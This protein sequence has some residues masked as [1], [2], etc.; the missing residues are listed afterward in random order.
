M[1]PIR[2]SRT[3][4]APLDVVFR[5]VSDVK[6]FREAVPHIVDVEFVT[7]QQIGAGTRIPID[8]TVQLLDWAYGGKAPEMLAFEDGQR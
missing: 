7:E 4:A 6:N 8:H 1:Q 3:I 5:T 2:F